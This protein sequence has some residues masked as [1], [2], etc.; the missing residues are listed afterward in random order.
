MTKLN[1]KPRKKWVI[2]ITS[3]IF[4]AALILFIPKV[5]EN[6]SSTLTL[7][8]SAIT[9]KTSKHFAWKSAYDIQFDEQIIHVK[10]LIEPIR[11]TDVRKVQFEKTKA[12]WKQ[13][14]QYVWSNKYALQ[15]WDNKHYPIQVSVEFT[16]L[17]AHH[18][19]I[20]RHKTTKIDTYNWGIYTSPNI[21]AH[22]FGHMIG[23]YDEYQGGAIDPTTLL[24]DPSSIMGNSKSSSRTYPRHY[25]NFQKWF[26]E[27]IKIKT[28]IVAIAAETS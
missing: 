27:N 19:I 28:K 25:T 13:K 21:I 10:V 9:Q 18:Q 14:I 20:I 5:I 17:K 6:R 23:A 4:G 1:I 26:S 8:E 15:T 3:V 11:T 22:E 16:K 2:L 24:I 7:T 12:I